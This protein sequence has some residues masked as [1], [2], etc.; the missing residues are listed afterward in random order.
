ME[1]DP[2]VIPD[3]SAFADVILKRSTPG[4]MVPVSALQ[5]ENGQTFVMVKAGDKVE[6]RPVTV[7][8]RNYLQ[9]RIESGLKAGEVVQLP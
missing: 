5:E 8:M 3:L 7:G 4:P 6:K 1:V 9:A 2:R